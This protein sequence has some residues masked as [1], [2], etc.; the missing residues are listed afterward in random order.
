MHVVNFGRDGTGILHMMDLAAMEVPRWNPDIVIFAFITDD[1][2]RARFWRTVIHNNGKD[3]VVTTTVPQQTPPLA[4]SAD[5]AVINKKATKEW[6]ARMV[7]AGIEDDPVLLE[8]EAVVNAARDRLSGVANIFTVK[9]SFLADYLLYQNAFIKFTDTIQASQ[10]PR[11]QLTDFGADKRFMTDLRAINSVGPTLTLLH[12]AVF[13]ELVSGNEYKMNN[14]QRNLLG[15]LERHLGTTAYGS[16]KVKE[17]DT[18]YASI[19]RSPDDA[20]PSVV[21]M[22]FYA[23]AAANAVHDM[24]GSKK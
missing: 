10:N 20:H 23:R 19:K 17:P 8:M 9:T 18:G 3:R 22:K 12:L 6:C 14:V 21:G 2:T 1:L 4:L 24:L 7:D 11:H 5:T 13:D 16:I 15:S